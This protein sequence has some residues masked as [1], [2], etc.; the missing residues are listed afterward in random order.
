MRLWNARNVVI[1]S[2]KQAPKDWVDLPT[3]SI[4][5]STIRTSQMETNEAQT[6][7]RLFVHRSQKA[8]IQKAKKFYKGAK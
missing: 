3:P 4:A 7:E 1:V 6:K 5:A 8:I 2:S